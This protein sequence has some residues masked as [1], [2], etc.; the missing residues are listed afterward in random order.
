MIINIINTTI[1]ISINLIFLTI[2]LFSCYG[3]GIIISKRSSV[4]FGFDDIFARCLTISLGMGIFIVICQLLSI[5]GLFNVHY[6]LLAIFFGLL[7][8][9]F[10]LKDKASHLLASV[11]KLLRQLKRDGLI[12][13]IR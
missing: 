3:L 9:V 11:A 7:I 8:C 12:L 2:F 5:L 6:L 10:S 13:S 4:L 1:F